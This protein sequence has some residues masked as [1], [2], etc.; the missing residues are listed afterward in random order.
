MRSHYR[1]NRFQLHR[2]VALRVDVDLDQCIFQPSA[3]LGLARWLHAIVMVTLLGFLLTRHL[4]TRDA[5]GEPESSIS[6]S[7]HATWHLP[8]RLDAASASWKLDVPRP[9]CRTGCMA[10]YETS[11]I[12]GGESATIFSVRDLGADSRNHYSTLAVQPEG[13]VMIT[14]QKCTSPMLSSR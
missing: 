10:R 2:T 13:L 8:F 5:R 4:A 6:V 9:T 11:I 3:G 7:V 12:E 1:P 14:T